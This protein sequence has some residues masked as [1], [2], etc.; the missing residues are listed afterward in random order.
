MN[1]FTLKF[2]VYKTI[3]NDNE[4]NEYIIVTDNNELE[5]VKDWYNAIFDKLFLETEDTIFNDNDITIEDNFIVIKGDTV[6]PQ[7]DDFMIPAYLADPDDDGNY[8]DIIDDI[9]YSP[10]PFKDSIEVTFN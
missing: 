7:E 9:N 5:K 2:Q 4:E 3:S 10:F 8:S 1:K 6:L